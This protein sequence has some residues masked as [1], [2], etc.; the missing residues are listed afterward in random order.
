MH[1]H[2]YADSVDVVFVARKG[3]RGGKGRA[4]AFGA[5]WRRV[6]KLAECIWNLRRLVKAERF[7]KEIRQGNVWLAEAGG[8]SWQR[9]LA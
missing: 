8:C 4:P 2:Q 1:R 7:N 3:R 9:L 5:R 6:T